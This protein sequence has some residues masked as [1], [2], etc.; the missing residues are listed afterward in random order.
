MKFSFHAVV[1]ADVAF[2]NVEWELLVHE[3]ST[4]REYGGLALVGGWFYGQMNQ[5]LFAEN[6]EDCE[7]SFTFRQIDLMIKILETPVWLGKNKVAWDLDKRLRTCIVEMNHTGT[8][9]Y[10]LLSTKTY[11]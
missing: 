11:A 4:S 5:R 3:V 10:N 7:L 8:E 9:L 1:M 2:T 6:K